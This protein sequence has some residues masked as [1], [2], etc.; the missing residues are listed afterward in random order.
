[1]LN[2]PQT[3]RLFVAQPSRHTLNIEMTLGQKTELT[4][5]AV[6]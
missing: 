4:D 5:R 6:S 2:V 1:M 3:Y